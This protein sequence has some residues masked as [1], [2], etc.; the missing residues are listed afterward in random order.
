MSGD[1][2]VV[3]SISWRDALPWLILFRVFRL[4]I[5]PTVLFL[6]TVGI[7][8]TP[9][10]WLVC[11]LAIG[12]ETTDANESFAEVVKAKSQMPGLPSHLIPSSPL[13]DDYQTAIGG[14]I[15][16]GGAPKV[17]DAL[18]PTH[19][20]FGAFYDYVAPYVQLFQHDLTVRQFFYLLSGAILTLCVWSIA[21][22][23]ITRIAAV[24]LGREERMPFQESIKHAVRKFRSYLAAPLMPLGGV[25]LL[26]IPAGL[27][28][29]L[30]QFNG[31]VVVVGILWIFIIICAFLSVLLLVGLF[32]G[33]P[34]MVAAISSENSDAFDA[35]SRSY[36]YTYQRPLN[37]FCYALLA[38]A[39]GVIGWVIVYVFSEGVIDMTWWAAAWGAGT[40]RVAEIRAD[41]SPVAAAQVASEQSENGAVFWVGA[42]VIAFLERVVRTFAS[43]YGFSFFWCAMTAIY[44]LLRHDVDNMEFDEIVLDENDIASHRLPPLDPPN[45]S[46]EGERR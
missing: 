35:L 12:P 1:T 16:G 7:V 45:A 33:W 18:A 23:A 6:A 31:A 10:C 37:Y 25:L 21:A 3:R 4:S 27:L 8:L 13:L 43:A 39:L 20:I 9:L 15:P 38:A 32:F 26:S 14:T 44:L 46:D 29:L 30:L 22:G 41:I 34:L 19:T 28:G 17:D 5:N 42:G 36:A 24:T 40:E 11:D 2:G